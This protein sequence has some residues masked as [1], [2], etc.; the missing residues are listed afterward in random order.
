MGKTDELLTLMLE[1]LREI[2]ATST[3]AQARKNAGR[4]INGVLEVG[5]YAL[6]SSGL[7]TRSYGTAIGSVVVSNPTSHTITVY[8]GPPTSSAMA[9]NGIGVF[10]VPAG[11]VQSIPID[12]HAVTLVGTAADV[13]SVQVWAGLQPFGV[14]Q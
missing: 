8:A 9:T 12:H 1:Q 10:V 4:S 7:W 13:F 5:T 2:N 6:D 11:S 14:N 3:L